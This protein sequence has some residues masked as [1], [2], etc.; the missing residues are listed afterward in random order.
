MELKKWLPVVGITLC[1]FVFNTSEF[2]PIGLLTDIARDFHIS[3]ARAGMLISVYAWMVALLS[4]PLMLLVCRMEM[5][6]LLLC[7]VGLFIVSHVASA[8]SQT[9][10]QL[11]LSRIG[12]ACAHS[13]FW[14][15]ASP[16]AVRTVPDSKRAA[17]LSIVA[18]G[19]SIAMV[20]GLPLGRVIG[21]IMGWRMTFLTIGIVAALIFVFLLAVLPV[22]PTRNSFSVKKMP[23]L[24]KD[25]VLAR[26]YIVTVLF[27]TAHYTGYSYIEPLLGQIG[28]FQPD[29][30]TLIL[31]FFGA[32]GTLGSYI[33]SRFYGG[34]PRAFITLSISVV[35]VSLLLLRASVLSLPSAILLCVAWSAAATAFNVA[36]Q[37]SILG[38]APEE[39]TAVAMSIF[40]GI[41]NLG[42]GSGAFIGGAVCTHIG[43]SQIGYMGATIAL[44]ATLVYRAKLGKMR[45]LPFSGK[46]KRTG[47]AEGALPS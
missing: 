13:V 28:R 32:A 9:Y 1:A 14:S 45:F 42:I 21:M 31:I 20:V 40:S 7:V 35:A 34:R 26:I 18:T 43:L 17:A 11:M 8:L 29:T 46:V 5:R 10:M 22:L 44:A 24:L 2:M 16:M 38:R 33:F 30:V 47:R 19:S 3:E 27:A 37:A 39:A 4:L 23:T 41:F 25:T 6:R 15:I 12:V 36:F